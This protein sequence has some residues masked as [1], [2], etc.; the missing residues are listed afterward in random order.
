[1]LKTVLAATTALT[2]AGST[3]AI[4]TL[5]YAQPG[6]RERDPQRR[7]QPSVEDVRAFQAAR[8]AALRAGL[9]LSTEQEKHWPA[10]EQAARE[11]QQLRVNRISALRDARREGQDSRAGRDERRSFDPAERMRQ[12]ATRMSEAGTVLKK[13]ADATEPLYRSLDDAQRRRFAVLTRMMSPP[14]CMARRCVDPIAASAA[15]T[16]RPASSSPACRWA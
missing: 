5:A 3:L 13:L 7:W 14:G 9:V 10:F 8:L 2:I 4:S 12:R 6:G 16:L 11:L 1:M 15:P